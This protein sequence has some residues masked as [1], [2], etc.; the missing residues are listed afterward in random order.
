MEIIKC[1]VCK[2]EK[3]SNE[4]GNFHGKLN[5]SCKTCRAYHN[6]RW[7]NNSQ[8][9]KVKRKSYYKA[10]K[11]KFQHRNFKNSILKKYGLS[12]EKYNQMLADQNNQCAIC[13]NEFELEKNTS[14][15]NKLPCV[16]HCHQTNKVRALLCRRCNIVLGIIE[17]GFIDK[18]KKYLQVHEIRIKSLID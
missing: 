7:T 13:K 5:K 11:E 15:I 1:T 12:L 8:G 6:N 14:N 17:S 10:N 2:K 9:E 16:D 4:F 18:A 3:N